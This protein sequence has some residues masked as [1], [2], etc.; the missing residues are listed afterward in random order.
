MHLQG[1]LSRYIHSINLCQIIKLRCTN[2]WILKKTKK[3]KQTNANI[4]CMIICINFHQY[5][6]K[7]W[8][9]YLNMN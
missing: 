1:I 5:T 4:H 7:E 6:A 9:K 3:F 8:V 2:F